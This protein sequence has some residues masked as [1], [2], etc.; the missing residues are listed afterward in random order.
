MISIVQ[1]E[2]IVRKDELQHVAHLCKLEIDSMGRI[3]VG[4]LRLLNLD[5]SFGQAALDQLSRLGSEGLEEIFSP[6]N[7]N[8]P[9][10]RPSV[11]C[12]QSSLAPPDNP[13]SSLNITLASLEAA[14]SDSQSNCATLS[15][16]LDTSDSSNPHVHNVQ[17]LTQ[18]LESMH[19]LL[20]KLRS[21]L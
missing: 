8:T 17:E 9:N 3:A 1:I 12:G 19:T 20:M 5:R 7:Q 11:D 14:L 2:V 18:K 6:R 10:K 21:Q 15:A 16:R 4:I 13:S